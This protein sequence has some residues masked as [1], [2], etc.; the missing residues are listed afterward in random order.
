M[1]N[2]NVEDKSRWNSQMKNALLGFEIFTLLATI[3]HNL[4]MFAAG[5]GQDVVYRWVS[6]ATAI[7]GETFAA[8]LLYL[9]WRSVGPTF[10]VSFACFI[11]IKAQLIFSAYVGF[12]KA[13]KGV[14]HWDWYTSGGAFISLLVTVCV[15][16]LIL[17]LTNPARKANQAELRAEIMAQVAEADE[18]VM[19]TELRIL[20][21]KVE[22]AQKRAL[23]Q[24]ILDQSGD[25]KL[26]NDAIDK[27]ARNHVRRLTNK[28]MNS[29]GESADEDYH[30]PRELDP[31]KDPRR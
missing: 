20:D 29:I 15:S 21:K 2:F 25:D 19:Q 26:T 6:G 4:Q 27:A 3:F 11:V 12:E 24:S 16:I 13:A 28:A 18:R 10:A 14:T 30:F 9:I 31:P 17:A 1:L 7:L 22:L 8:Y 23:L 5:G